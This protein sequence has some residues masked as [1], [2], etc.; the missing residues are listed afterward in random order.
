[1]TAT[2]TKP[3]HELSIEDR[4][5]R[6]EHALAAVALRLTSNYPFRGESIGVAAAREIVAEFEEAAAELRRAA[7]RDELAGRLAELE[8]A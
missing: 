5:T 8:A 1:V 3:T 7:E 2:S 6:L 4:L